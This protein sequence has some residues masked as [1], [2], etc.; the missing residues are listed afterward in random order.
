MTSQANT[1]VDACRILSGTGLVE[2]YTGH[3]SWQRAVDSIEI[4]VH[5]HGE[6]RGLESITEQHIITVDREGEPVS[7]AS[8]E[9]PEEIVI[10]T[11]I[12]QQRADVSSVVHAHPLYATGWSA[13]NRELDPASLDGL[14]FDGPVPIHDAGP[15]LLTTTGDGL[16]LARDLE[17]GGAILIRGHGAVTVG[18]TVEEATARMWLLERACR[19][20]CIAERAGGAV[21]F[22]DPVDPGFLRGDEDDPFRELFTFLLENH[23]ELD[24]G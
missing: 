12:L 22:E 23:G 2:A 13:T 18:S 20:Q 17:T 14:L 19:L 15:N 4:P 3:V 21:P 6:G 16:K 11:G 24:R 7:S 8:V 5:L 10:H 1:L 9:P